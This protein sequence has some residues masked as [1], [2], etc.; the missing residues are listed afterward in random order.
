MGLPGVHAQTDLSAAY[1]L[2]SRTQRR[3]S[4]VPGF[5]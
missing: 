5:R 2:L 4:R 3:R 1:A